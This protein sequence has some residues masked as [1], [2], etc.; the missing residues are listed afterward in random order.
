MAATRQEMAGLDLEATT[1]L[2][3]THTGLKEEKEISRFTGKKQVCMFIY[4]FK[5]L[6]NYPK[7]LWNMLIIYLEIS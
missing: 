5:L 3:I 1:G 6:H 2:D 7:M 4:Y